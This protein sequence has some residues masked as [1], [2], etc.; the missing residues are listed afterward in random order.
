M[1]PVQR[2]CLSLYGDV[3]GTTTSLLRAQRHD[4]AEKEVRRI[5]Q[6]SIQHLDMKCM[7]VRAA[8]LYALGLLALRLPDASLSSSTLWTFVMRQLM[9]C[10][11]R[12]TCQTTGTHRYPIVVHDR[13][14]FDMAGRLLERL[15]V[16]T[17]VGVLCHQLTRAPFDRHD[18]FLNSV[19]CNMS[20]ITAIEVFFAMMSRPAPHGKVFNAQCI[21]HMLST[22]I[23]TNVE[24]VLHH[25]EQQVSSG[26]LWCLMHVLLEM[27][28][29]EDCIDRVIT[30]LERV[31]VR[32]GVSD[33][34]GDPRSDIYYRVFK[35]M[36]YLWLTGTSN[37]SDMS[38]L[39][40][41]LIVEA[42]AR[43]LDVKLVVDMMASCLL[44]LP[45][46][47]VVI[48]ERVVNLIQLLV[49]STPHGS[50]L[51]ICQRPRYIEKLLRILLR[52]PDATL[53]LTPNL[54]CMQLM[55]VLVLP[56]LSSLIRHAARH[57]GSIPYEF[58]VDLIRLSM[59]RMRRP[60][61]GTILRH[62]SIDAQA[63][64]AERMLGVWKQSCMA[65]TN[66]SQLHDLQSLCHL[67]HLD[68]AVAW[69]RM[70]TSVETHEQRLQRVEPDRVGGDNIVCPI[71]QT[72][73][74]RPL[75][76]DDGYTY[77]EAAIMRWISENGPASP[78]TR[79][80]V[81]V[82]G[83]NV[84]LVAYMDQRIEEAMAATPA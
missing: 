34:D 75:S 65:A 39:C 28:L 83:L 78:M 82:H 35:I 68:I 10:P 23:S 19:L 22:D 66:L 47:S 9:D 11:V 61:F 31:I 69:Q 74:Y 14:W 44:Q 72:R 24:R 60:G 50:T 46:L 54:D 62:R 52:A 55:I 57:L 20:S 40:D 81:R 27:H 2:T 13:W 56:S 29:P 84:N 49:T 63:R 6:G 26:A 25:V 3:W 80:P 37:E 73:M 18:T 32:H 15:P 38:R 5:L 70:L 21:F 45:S 48:M 17:V 4:D 58:P 36:E 1:S 7:E 43:R 53:L 12:S 59:E 30:T 51:E 79:Q 41:A 67:R 16:T 42:K 64:V 71:E 77:E 33:I 76:L 8:T